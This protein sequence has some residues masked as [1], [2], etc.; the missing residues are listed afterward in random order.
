M[1]EIVAGTFMMRALDAQLGYTAGDKPQ[2]A[3][4]LEYEEGPNIGQTRTW[5][6]YF[7]DKT[8]TQTIKSLRALGLQGN[9]L[10]DLS[11][12]RNSTAC[13]TR[14]E[15]NQDGELVAKIAW[16]GAGTGVVMKNQMTP[17]Q[18]RAFAAAFK[19]DMAA[20]PATEKREAPK[21]IE[22]PD[23]LQPNGQPK[24]FF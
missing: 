8:K 21:P 17:E 4:L 5:Y 14:L 12:V 10:S 3:V 13:V 15:P 9:D 1:S 22:G 7:T 23:A 6:G 16:V 20:N 11:S 19:A 2:V 18:A 24:A